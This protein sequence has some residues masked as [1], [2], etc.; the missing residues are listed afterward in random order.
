MNI[1][2]LKQKLANIDAA[3]LQDFILD[4]YL[5]YPELNDKTE[6]GLRF[7]GHGLLPHPVAGYFNAGA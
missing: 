1:D 3:T 5:R 4:L 6:G 2:Q 7:G